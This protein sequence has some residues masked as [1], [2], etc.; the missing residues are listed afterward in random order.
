M[1]VIISQI[2]GFVFADC[3]FHSTKLID[4]R[5]EFIF[6]ILVKEGYGQYFHDNCSQ[7]LYL[8]IIS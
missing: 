6:I 4:E 2:I 8:F 5:L 1:M 3:K 7:D